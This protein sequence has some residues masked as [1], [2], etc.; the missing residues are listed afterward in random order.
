MQRYIDASEQGDAWAVADMLT[1]DVRFSMPPVPGVWEGRNEVVESW[2]R[3]CSDADTEAALDLVDPQFEMTEAPS[4]PGDGD[5]AVLEAI[6]VSFGD[7]AQV[8]YIG[9]AS[10]G[11]YG[12][13]A[14]VCEAVRRWGTAPLDELAASLM[15][16][17]RVSRPSGAARKAAG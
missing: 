15:A 12:C 7:A 11:V 13:P 16:R 17:P 10:C 9:P 1:E 3:A 2:M 8:F 5:G 4:P 6:D 14:G